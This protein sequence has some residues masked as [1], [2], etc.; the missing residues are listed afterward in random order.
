MS[1]RTLDCGPAWVFTTESPHVL[2]YAVKFIFFPCFL[3]AWPGHP[4]PAAW[5]H[6]SPPSTPTRRPSLSSGTNVRPLSKASA[7]STRG[8]LLDISGNILCILSLDLW[9]CIPARLRKAAG[10]LQYLLTLWT[11]VTLQPRWVKN[12]AEKGRSDISWQKCCRPIS[13]QH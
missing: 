12:S 1:K 6:L 10:K 13:G 4:S 9:T 2:N 7:R 3:S 11:L 5:A 8:R